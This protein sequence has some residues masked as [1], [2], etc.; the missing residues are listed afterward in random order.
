MKAKLAAKAMAFFLVGA[1]LVALLL[2]LP[3]GTLSYPGAWRLMGLLFI[4]MLILGV[5]LLIFAPEVL[6][7]RLNAKEKMGDQKRVVGVTGV[8]FLLGF[9]LAGLDFRFGWTAVPGWLI[10]LAS[11]VFVASY[12]MY[13][14]V[15]RE[16]AWI[17]RTIEIQE[18]QKVVSTGLY[19]VVR[20]PMYLAAS[21]LFTS[22]PLVMG[23]FVSFAVFLVFPLMMGVRIRGEEELLMRELDGY[24]AYRQKVRYKMIPF[25]W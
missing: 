24:A 2:F 25:I 14:E 9:V 5:L 17:S 1:A 16:N 10:A 3:A 8:V 19:G 12:A 4:P 23:S 6:K 7:K 20:H 15:M 22:M 18:G 11:L 21:L 13:G